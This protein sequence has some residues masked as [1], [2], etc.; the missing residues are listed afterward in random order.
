MTA[1]ALIFKYKNHRGEI[2]KRR[3]IPDALEFFLDPG[4]DYQTGWFLSGFDLDK[5]ARRSFALCNI[6]LEGIGQKKI[7]SLKI[8]PETTTQE[9]DA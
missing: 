7:F 2:A 8:G 1:K 5:N 6:Q 9:H 4:Y 3:I